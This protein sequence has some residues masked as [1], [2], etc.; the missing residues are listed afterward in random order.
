MDQTGCWET[1]SYN[2]A[3]VIGTLTDGLLWTAMA[4]KTT[5]GEDLQTVSLCFY[6]QPSHT[7]LATIGSKADMGI[8]GKTVLT[9]LLRDWSGFRFCEFAEFR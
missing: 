4:A 9:A 3:L 1:V 2:A 8:F 5:F 7:L 6:G